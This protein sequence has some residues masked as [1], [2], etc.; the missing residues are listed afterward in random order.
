M[1]IH[2]AVLFEVPCENVEFL[3]TKVIPYCMRDLVP[4]YPTTLEGVPDG[5]GPY[6]LGYAVEIAEHWGENLT[7]ERKLE[8]GIPLSFGETV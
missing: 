1:Q 3:V 8:L 2:D 4:I 7:D 6:F 5:R